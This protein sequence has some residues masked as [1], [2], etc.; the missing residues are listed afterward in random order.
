MGT[1]DRLTPEGN[2]SGRCQ[3][4]V[5]YPPRSASRL[6]TLT[7]E[8]RYRLGSERGSPKAGRTVFSKRVMAQIRSP[9]RVRT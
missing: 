7:P 6:L 8:A 3:K 1:A 5:T 2:F 9:L 4:P